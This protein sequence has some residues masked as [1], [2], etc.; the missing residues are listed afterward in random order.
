MWTFRRYLEKS[1]N[2]W[3]YGHPFIWRK[4]F[5]PGV[6]KILI[7]VRGK[8]L[9]WH[10]RI[11][12]T[13]SWCWEYK[14]LWSMLRWWYRY[15]NKKQL[16]LSQNEIMG[17]PHLRE[18]ETECFGGN[19]SLIKVQE[20]HKLAEIRYGN[21]FELSVLYLSGL[22]MATCFYLHNSFS[23]LRLPNYR[24]ILFPLSVHIRDGCPMFAAAPSDLDSLK[25]LIS[26]LNGD[27]NVSK[28][29]THVRYNRWVHRKMVEAVG[30]AK[31][32]QFRGEFSAFLQ[33]I[34][35]LILRWLLYS[36]IRCKWY[37]CH[38]ILC[39]MLYS[40]FQKGLIVSNIP[41]KC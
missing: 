37:N 24:F 36:A 32:F 2:R 41:A 3:V 38:E 33:S 23:S 31:D 15:R 7:S 27:E 6:P 20:G 8:I 13:I 30:N 9:S 5:I 25:D 39:S 17:Y 35:V 10:A 19:A 34:W 14:I 40:I 11:W 28:F 26:S 21:A 16:R 18:N 4:H 12:P 29:A 1:Q 22:N